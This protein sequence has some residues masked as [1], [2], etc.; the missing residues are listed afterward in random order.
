VEAGEIIAVCSIVVSVITT[1]LVTMITQRNRRIDALETSL[2]LAEQTS[3]TKQETIA[4]LR[5][6][7]DRLTITAEIQER[8][9]RELP[10]HLP[11]SGDR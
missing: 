10:R 11:P 4:E 8:F 6:Q 7:V 3:E 1:T 5:R 9:F 2:R